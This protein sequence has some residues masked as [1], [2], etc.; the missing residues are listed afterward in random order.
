MITRFL[1]FL[2]PFLTSQG[3][4]NLTRWANLSSLQKLNLS[5]CE[6]L[7]NENVKRFAECCPNLTHLLIAWCTKVRKSFD[8]LS[9][10]KLLPMVSA[11]LIVECMKKA[12]GW[13]FK[14]NYGRGAVSS[15]LICTA[16][17]FSPESR[18]W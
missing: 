5:E 15:I 3:F 8:Q 10:F 14:S 16:V 2:G 9:S 11:V 12:I 7:D 6:L 18:G 1:S 17:N 13:G 4:N